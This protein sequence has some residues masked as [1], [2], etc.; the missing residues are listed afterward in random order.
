[1]WMRSPSADRVR[2]GKS[3]RLFRS[4]NRRFVKSIC[5]SVTHVAWLLTMIETP[6][7]AA[8]FPNLHLAGSVEFLLQAPEDH[9]PWGPQSAHW[10]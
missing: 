1:M 7:Y 9:A 5:I 4:T 6:R 10:S 2:S 3:R 8:V